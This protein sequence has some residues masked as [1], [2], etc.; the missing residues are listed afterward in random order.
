M[1]SGRFFA[2]SDQRVA[3]QYDAAVAEWEQR[4]H[5]DLEEYWPKSELPYG[6]MTH[7]LQGGVPNHGFTH[8][9]TLFNPRQL[10]VNALLLKAIATVG[11][12]KHKFSTREFV[13][14]AFQQFIRCNTML[15]IWHM[16]NNQ[17]S[18]ALSNSNFHPK[19][20]SLEQYICLCWGW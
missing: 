18:A 13:M 17:I 6:F 4:R 2:G 3:K 14:G 20:T 19:S 8:W 10:L 7:H 15:S 5:G 12:S 9:W 16:K 1:N 11:G